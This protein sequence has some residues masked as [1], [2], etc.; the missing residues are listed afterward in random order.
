MHTQRLTERVLQV[1]K[2]SKSADPFISDIIKDFFNNSVLRL[3]AWR[4]NQKQASLFYRHN[5][6]VCLL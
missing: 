5:N 2:D 6:G 4:N 1:S 3:R